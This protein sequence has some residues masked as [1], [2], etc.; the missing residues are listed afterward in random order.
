[1]MQ[2]SAP[3]EPDWDMLGGKAISDPVASSAA[4]VLF[5][6][7]AGH[8]QELLDTQPDALDYV[9][10]ILRKHVEPV[11]GG[12]TYGNLMTSLVNYLGPDASYLLAWLAQAQADPAEQQAR[13]EALEQHAREF[14]PEVVAFYRAI[15]GTFGQEM[16]LALIRSNELPDNWNVIS[17][18]VLYDVINN[19]FLI[20]LTIEKFNGEKTVIEGPPDSI[21]SLATGII[22]T[23]RLVDTRDVF[24]QD[25]IDTFLAEAEELIALL[26]PEPEPADEAAE[27]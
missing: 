5:P 9:L 1:M 14:S 15:I 6:P 2:A 13:F 17:R 16:E 12:A 19:S 22:I 20:Q 8:I 11:I 23:A 27:K 24:S 26:R 10:D 3:Q 25:R 18:E 4:E 21:L 7:V